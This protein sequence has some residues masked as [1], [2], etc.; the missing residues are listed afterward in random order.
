MPASFGLYSSII[1]SVRMVTAPSMR[2]EMA[3]SARVLRM[4]SSD[5]K[6]VEMSP[7]DRLS[8][9]SQ[10]RPI[11]CW[12]RLAAHWMASCWFSRRVIHPRAMRMRNSTSAST[13]PPS[14]ATSSRSLSDVTS[15]PSTTH[16]VTWGTSSPTISSPIAMTRILVSAIFRPTMVPVSSRSFTRGAFLTFWNEALGES[17]SAMPVKC[18]DTSRRDMTRLPLP[19]S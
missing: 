18:G 3:P 13:P 17:S 11:R 9:N 4:D 19:G 2:P 5:W 10:G 12:N 6:R 14:T 15:A 16:W 7:S 1:P 8:K